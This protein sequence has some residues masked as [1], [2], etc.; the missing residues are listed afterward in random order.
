[1]SLSSPY[2]GTSPHKAWLRALEMTAPIPRNP[3]LTL[4]VLIVNQAKKFGTAPALLAERECLTYQDLADRSI[5]Y[6]RWAQRQG[7]EKAMSSV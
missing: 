6:A 3:S 2:N 4:P 7:L 5:Q 1:M